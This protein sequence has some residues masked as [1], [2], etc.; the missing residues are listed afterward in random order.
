MHNKIIW[1]KL[2]FWILTLNS[3]FTFIINNNDISR[4]QIKSFSFIVII[5]PTQM[6][7]F[8]EDLTPT[9]QRSNQIE[10]KLNSHLYGFKT[11]LS[12]QNL[13]NLDERVETRS[14]TRNMLMFWETICITNINPIQQ[15]W[16]KRTSMTFN[17][18]VVKDFPIK[19]VLWGAVH[20]PSDP[21]D[22]VFFKMFFMQNSIEIYVIY[23]INYIWIK[24]LLHL[25]NW[26]QCQQHQKVRNLKF[27]FLLI[28]S[29]LWFRINAIL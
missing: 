19:I 7:A 1:L 9:F 15:F 13:E 5:F 2:I 28:G 8:F 11:K 16:Q 29:S 3:S 10:K 6:N 12:S 27:I 24:F 20:L 22:A 21:E 26:E 18:Y 17:Y 4:I 23:V 14:W 25:M